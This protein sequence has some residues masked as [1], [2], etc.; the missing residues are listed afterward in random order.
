MRKTFFV[1]EMLDEDQE[2]CS[3]CP[4]C[5]KTDFRWFIDGQNGWSVACDSCW[6]SGPMCYDAS[7]HNNAQIAAINE[8]NLCA[9]EDDA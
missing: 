4:W 6:A 8:W 2:V 3:P 7:N 9:G 5:E 1:L